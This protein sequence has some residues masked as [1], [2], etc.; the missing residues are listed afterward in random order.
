MKATVSMS[1]KGRVSCWSFLSAWDKSLVDLTGAKIKSSILGGS[2]NLRAGVLRGAEDRAFMLLCRAPI[3]VLSWGEL[4]GQEQRACACLQ[5]RQHQ[6]YGDP[7]KQELEVWNLK[8]QYL[9]TFLRKSKTQLPELI[10]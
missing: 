10:L 1:E 5:L 6:G 9:A 2:K 7:R 4:T 8:P 3:A